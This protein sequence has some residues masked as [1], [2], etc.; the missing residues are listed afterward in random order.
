MSGRIYS[1]NANDNSQL[2]QFTTVP[3]RDVRQISRRPPSHPDS[4]NSTIRTHPRVPQRPFLTRSS[5]GTF[6][7]FCT[8]DVKRS[9]KERTLNRGLRWSVGGTSL[10]VGGTLARRDL[11]AVK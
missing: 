3:E 11:S 6:M 5:C 1:T 7:S 4:L 10:R 9:M 2:S 8:F